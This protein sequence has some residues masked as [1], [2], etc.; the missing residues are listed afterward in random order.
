MAD[1]DYTRGQ[2]GGAQEEM[3]VSRVETQSQQAESLTAREPLLKINEA[4]KIPS[5]ADSPRS[6]FP[7][8]MGGRFV[9][10]L[11]GLGNRPFWFFCDTTGEFFA[12]STS[13]SCANTSKLSGTKEPR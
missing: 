7:M 9:L 11:C 2:Q 8:A 10:G 13:R 5:A 1:Q 4:W 3:K 12:A 6:R